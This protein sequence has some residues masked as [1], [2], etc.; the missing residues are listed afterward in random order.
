MSAPLLDD[1]TEL[2]SRLE[3]PI[4]AV[5]LSHRNPDGDALGSSLALM[6]YLR[7]LQHTSDVIV[8]SEYPKVFEYL[9]D[10]SGISIYDLDKEGVLDK[11]A[12][13]DILFC[14]DFNSLDRVDPLAEAITESKAYKCMIDHHLDPEPFAD[15]YMSDPAAS[16]TCELVYRFIEGRDHVSMIDVAVGTC[17]F[18][19]MVTDTGSFKYA[20]NPEVYRI[21]SKLKKVGVDDYM[22]NDQIFNSWTHRQLYTDD[23]GHGG[24]C[25]HQR[26]ATWRDK[27]L[28]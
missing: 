26:D 4:Y 5:I 14:L 19:G 18:T 22:I 1:I 7:K 8:P 23:R 17:I 24:C 13:A 11:I 6:H 16:S 25:I 20:T 21:S 28:L 3:R 27:T 15:W 2:Q 12:K 9:P 10:V